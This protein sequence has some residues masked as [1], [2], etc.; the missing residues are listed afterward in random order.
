M[1]SGFDNVLDIPLRPEN[2]DECETGS[3]A[4]FAEAPLGLAWRRR[5]TGH[6]FGKCSL[7][8]Q[9]RNGGANATLG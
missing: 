9:R 4:P 8:Q 7:A 1:D 2:Q 6:G 5:V 3:T